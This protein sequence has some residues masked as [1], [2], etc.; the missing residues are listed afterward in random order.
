MKVNI[1]KMTAEID[2]S[3]NATYIVKDGKLEPVD[4]PP[5]GFGRQI[6]TWQDG[7]QVMFGL[8]YTKRI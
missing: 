7:K 6:I 4:T 3:K 1:D 2:L 5:N 8:D